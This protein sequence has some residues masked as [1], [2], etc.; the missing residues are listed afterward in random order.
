MSTRRRN[1]L[2]AQQEHATHSGAIGSGC[3]G[4]PALACC[5][6]NRAY[7]LLDPNVSDYSSLDCSVVVYDVHRML[8][9]LDDGD[10]LAVEVR[11]ELAECPYGAQLVDVESKLRG[12]L[13]DACEEHAPDHLRLRLLS[14]IHRCCAEQP[15]DGDGLDS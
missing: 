4:N 1:L 6:V 2:A 3:A 8:H 15:T 13:H 12:K 10:E 9:Q 14:H 11:E 7:A 5:P